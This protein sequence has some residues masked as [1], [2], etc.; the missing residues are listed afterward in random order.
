MGEQS[1]SQEVQTQP[2]NGVKAEAEPDEVP[3]VEMVEKMLDAFDRL[4]LW[5]ALGG[6][7]LAGSLSRKSTAASS[8]TFN[9]S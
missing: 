2:A 6:E 8:R 7:E 1:C 5:N 4:G 3:Y 9:T